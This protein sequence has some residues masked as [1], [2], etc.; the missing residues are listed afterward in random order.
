MRIPTGAVLVALALG[1]ARA[2]GAETTGWHPPTTTAGSVIHLVVGAGEGS[3]FDP[4]RACVGLPEGWEVTR[5]TWRLALPG[6]GRKGTARWEVG[7]AEEVAAPA[8]RP[9]AH[10]VAYP[11][12]ISTRE[13]DAAW[14]WFTFRFRVAEGSSGDQVLGWQA[15]SETPG[16]GVVRVRPGPPD[17]APGPLGEHP[18]WAARIFA[19]MWRAERQLQDC[20]VLG[21]GVERGLEVEAPPEH[22]LPTA[23]SFFEPTDPLLLQLGRTAITRPENLVSFLGIFSDLVPDLDGV[24]IEARHNGADLD[25]PAAVYV[26]SQAVVAEEAR[27]ACRAFLDLWLEP[28]RRLVERELSRPTPGSG[29]ALAHLGPALDLVEA[30]PAWFDPPTWTEL[31][32]LVAISAWGE[33][34]HARARELATECLERCGRQGAV[35]VSHGLLANLVPETYDEHCPIERT[36]DSLLDGP[37]ALDRLA[38]VYCGRAAEAG[39]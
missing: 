38:V 19:Q 8:D 21:Q 24:L 22:G 28:R 11:G 37:V 25:A 9:G 14:G 31:A 13:E 3:A 10:C 12:R 34:D 29:A 39:L 32:P 26:A 6:K 4:P 23:E 17:P 2:G 7:L 27:K 5:G 30:L 36:F 16:Q 33:G 20:R 18:E 1:E 35:D 15:G